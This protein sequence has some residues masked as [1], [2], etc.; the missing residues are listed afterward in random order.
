MHERLPLWLRAPLIFKLGLIQN[1][2]TGSF[3]VAESTSDDPARGGG[4]VLGLADEFATIPHS[5]M[6][7]SALGNAVVNLTLLSTP[8]G[9]ANAHGRIWRQGS[10]QYKKVNILW[11]DPETGANIHEGRDRAWRDNEVRRLNLLPHLAAQELDGSYEG[12]V[13]YRILYN[14]DAS[15][16][17]TPTPYRPDLA[18]YSFWDFGASSQTAIVFC[19]V[20]IVNVRGV[21]L[22]RL[23][24]P[25]A[26]GGSQKPDREFA[27]MYREAL[28]AMGCRRSRDYGD[29]SGWGM[30]I[31]R[32]KVTSRIRNLADLGI[33]LQ[34]APVVG[35]GREDMWNDARHFLEFREPALVQLD[36]VNAADLG[37]DMENY[38]YKT[39][40][41]GRPT[42]DPD[43]TK[44]SSHFSD[45]YTFAACMFRH[46]ARGTSPGITTAEPENASQIYRQLGAPESMLADELGER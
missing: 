16:H 20:E 46:S 31:E 44:F 45:A 8:K 10:P 25:F 1:P 39:D 40:K 35:M 22:W 42:G 38:R 11:S 32:E 36:P 12:S 19:Q 17:M 23:R 9:K 6:V 43:K 18:M 28:D 26:V 13:P 7:L 2:K 34:K 30:Q 29:P 4:F 33:H 37:W 15:I 41:E 27:T 5:E 24:F 21:D 14:Y 3:L